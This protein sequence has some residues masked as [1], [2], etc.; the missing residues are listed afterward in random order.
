R[1]FHVTGVQTCALP[2]W[3]IPADTLTWSKEMYAI[4]G[5]DPQVEVTQ[6]AHFSLVHPQDREIARSRVAQLFASGE[7]Q[8]FEERIIRPDGEV[9]HLKTWIRLKSDQNSNPLYMIGACI[10]ITENKTYEE[11]LLAS[12]RRLRN[13]LDSQ[14]NYV[15][16]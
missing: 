12:E 5:I 14:T 11:R 16:R 4:F 8:I 7:D 1:D 10:D 6:E 13:I 9:R 3:D 2:I 15:V